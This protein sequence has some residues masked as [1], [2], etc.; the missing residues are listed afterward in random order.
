MNETKDK[1]NTHGAPNTPKCARCDFASTGRY[2]RQGFGASARSGSFY[3]V[4]HFC[5][6]PDCKRH[7]IFYGK[8]S[9][10]T[11]PLKKNKREV[12]P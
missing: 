10:T 3:Q 6:H 9:P 4:G 2:P 11:C 5:N 12:T 7:L 1:E 8:T